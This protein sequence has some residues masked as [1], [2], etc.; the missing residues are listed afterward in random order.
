MKQPLI[1]IFLAFADDLSLTRPSGT[2]LVA[3]LNAASVP[4]NAILGI[5][6]DH[7]S[8]RVVIL[9]SCIGS[10]L[11]CAFLWG[12]GTNDGMLIAFTI[13]FGL[14][15]PSFSALWTKMNAVISSK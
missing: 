13:I 7:M 8:L 11:A 3:I 15:G 2:G 10:G 14:L 12:F 5:M 4:G 9:I 1:V 6:S